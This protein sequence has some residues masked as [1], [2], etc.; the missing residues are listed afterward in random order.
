MGRWIP[1]TGTKLSPRLCSPDAIRSQYLKKNR[2]P[3]LKIMEEATAI[4]AFFMFPARLKRSTSMP[5]V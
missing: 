2:I 1:N 4:R 3:R 5:W